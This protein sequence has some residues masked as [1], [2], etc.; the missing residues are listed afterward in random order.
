MRRRCEVVVLWKNG[1]EVRS[2]LKLDTDKFDS[3][4]FTQESLGR[5]MRP[6]LQ[7]GDSYYVARDRTTGQ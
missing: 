1:T 2:R 7:K 6:I 4:G 5:Y 3:I